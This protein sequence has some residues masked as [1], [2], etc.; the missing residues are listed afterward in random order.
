MS[1]TIPADLATKVIGADL[2]NL[3]K[4]VGEGS[5]LSSSERAMMERAIADGMLTEELIQRRRAALM[6][7]YATGRRLSKEEQAE[8]ADI[9][10]DAGEVERRVTRER[11]QH[12]LD[13]YAGRYGYA[14]RNVKKWLQVGRGR[15]PPDLPPL[16]EPAEMPAWWGR[17]MKQRCPKRLLMT[18]EPAAPPADAT[19]KPAPSKEAE[20]R[21]PPK[22]TP[23][24]GEDIKGTGYA[25]MIARATHAELV[26]WEA[27][28]GA[29]KAE[30]FDA[31]QEEMRRRAYDR[32]VEQARKVLKDRDVGLAGDEEWGRWE[33]FEE[34]AQEH[35]AVLNQSLRSMP[36]RV[37]TKLALPPEMFQRLADAFN[38]ELDR[39]FARLDQVNWRPAATGDE[40]TAEPENDFALASE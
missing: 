10:P 34:I 16:D 1:T 19:A 14:V 23:A 36:V 26:A 12:A 4:K 38:G 25:A 33:E 7:A 6:H 18:I 32:A 27:W 17:N 37:A 2:R 24:A 5:V 15:T 40:P 35:L 30:P 22:T 31:G 3:V 28:Q 20:H 11:Y 9:L 21:P 8:I 29:L 13:H 39:I